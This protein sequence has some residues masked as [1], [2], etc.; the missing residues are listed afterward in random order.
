MHIHQWYTIYTINSIE[1]NQ[2]NYAEEHW[3][4]RWIVAF[5][6]TDIKWRYI[7]CNYFLSEYTLPHYIQSLRWNYMQ[8]IA[9]YIYNHMKTYRNTSKS[10]NIIQCLLSEL[11][12]PSSEYRHNMLQSYN[13]NRITDIYGMYLLLK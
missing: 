7:I 3:Y 13:Y 1:N 12:H 9:Y 2:Y 11:V 4:R 5:N 6:Y 10:N 8:F